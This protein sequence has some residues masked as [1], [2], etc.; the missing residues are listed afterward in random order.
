MDLID[1]LQPDRERPAPR[2]Y[3][4]ACVSFLLVDVLARNF[5]PAIAGEVHFLFYLPAV[6][7]SAWY[8]GPG[9]GALCTA[10]GAAS[11]VSRAGSLSV[12]EIA[13]VAIFLSSGMLIVVLY[14]AL[15]AALRRARDILE[16]MHDAFILLDREVRFRY[17]NREA[18]KLWGR[19]REDL[20]GREFKEVFP[21]AEGSEAHQ[22]IERSLADHRPA[23]LETIGPISKVWLELRLRPFRGGVGVYFHDITA[24]KTAE[25]ELL[26]RAER[27]DARLKE[28]NDEL[29]VFTYSASHDL[30]GPVRRIL[31]YCD[32]IALRAAPAL[33]EE[34]RGWFERIRASAENIDRIID[35][36]QNLADA[37]Q[38]ELRPETVDLSALARELFEAVRR[39]APERRCVFT[40]A[41]GL[42]GRADERLFR[43]ALSNIIDNAWK[44]TAMKDEARI[45]FG[46]ASA[47][48]GPAFFV[49]DNGVGFDM[50]HADKL[51]MAFERLNPPEAFPGM[52]VGLA[53]TQRVIHR[54]GGRIWAESRPGE[55]S[56]FYFTL[57]PDA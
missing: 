48:D 12:S 10:L 19:R 40:A 8:G 35:E 34:Q 16:T 4:A 13:R 25:K 27:V 49:M 38:R 31:N 56:V 52:G 20:L 50:A 41:P 17:V 18:E 32:M 37:T 47:P 3:A 46:A 51:F 7:L 24:H 53:I 14:A 23:R 30:R 22:A 6:V 5:D 55:G 28:I 26:G 45:E 54:H 1:R 44:F 33:P 2:R 11:A 21:E 36:M 29:D 42:T 39:T 9:P 15:S 43:I 57:P